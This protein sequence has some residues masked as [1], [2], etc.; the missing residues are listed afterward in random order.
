MHDLHDLHDL[1]ELRE[2]RSSTPEADPTAQL[3]A[4]RA[5]LRAAVAPRARKRHRAR[6]TTAIGCAGLVVAGG[7]VAYAVLAGQAPQT[8]LKVNC[9]VGVTQA[10]F[11]KEHSFTSILDATTGDPVADCAA[12][13]QRLQGSAP[14][15]TAYDV[16]ASFVFV[17]PADWTV[18]T[19]WRPLPS[20]FQNDAAR[21]E[22][23]Q[24][25]ED[26]VDGPESRCSTT[27]DAERD[28]RADLASLSLTGWSLT[29]LPSATKADGRNACAFATID[30]ASSLTINIGSKSDITDITDINGNPVVMTGRPSPVTDLA[31]RL[32]SDISRSCVTLQ[33]SK[34][35]VLRAISASGLRPQDA[36]VQTIPDNAASCTRVALI[37]GGMINIILRGPEHSV[38]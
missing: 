15:L 24:R 1:H 32:R 17:L 21:L 30:E 14:R 27:D 35:I 33:A 26:L 20:T 11:D 36:N 13:Y 38:D 5:T 6:Q 18:P 12:Q 28:A 29:R 23:K 3:R 25:L 16:G 31:A 19:S 22:L 34:G 37:P 4:R 8:A 10:Q 9:A 7:G 2:F